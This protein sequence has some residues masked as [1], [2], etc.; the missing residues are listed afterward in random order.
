MANSPELSLLTGHPFGCPCPM[1]ARKKAL[2]TE[3]HLLMQRIATAQEE[4]K[5]S[6][7]QKMERELETINFELLS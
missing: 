2:G 6:E 3:G 1:C 4:G 7:V 5:I